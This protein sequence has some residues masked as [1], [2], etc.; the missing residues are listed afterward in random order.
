M[1]LASLC[2]A[3]IALLGAVVC[4]ERLVDQIEHV[5]IFMQENRPMDHYFGTLQGVRGFN[6]RTSVPLRS[7]FNAFHQPI[8]QNNLDEYMLPF[9]AESNKTNAMCMPA[10]EMYYPT[11][12]LMWNSGRMDSWNT[13]RD[14]GMGM[15]YYTRADLPYYY[16]LYDN[17]VCGDQ[18]FQSTF[19]STTP[20]RLVFFSG[21]N[22]LSV[23]EEAI[24]QN[25]E[26]RPGYNWTTMGEILEENNVS[27]RVYQ[28]ADNFDDNGFAWF[29]NYQ[30]SRPGDV[31]FEK[32]MRRQRNAI[33]AFHDD[34]ANNTLPQV[35]WII[36]PTRKSEHATNHPCDGED[37]TARV[38]AT[39]SSFPDIYAKSLFILNYD[40]GKLCDP[41]LYL[42][43]LGACALLRYFRWPL[44]VCFVF[45]LLLFCDITSLRS[46]AAP[47]PANCDY[48]ILNCTVLNYSIPVL[49]HTMLCC[50]CDLPAAGGY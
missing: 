31:L 7:G 32:G 12:I 44:F 17:F 20:N 34:L 22:G 33:E 49:Y 29:Y 15:S 41:C 23:G 8:D 37:F 25:D 45:V 6:D 11:D 16:T 14:P 27:W 42:C 24:L 40:E 36:A 2:L 39:L 13:A 30:K 43:C 35:S 19:T 26:P 1:T 46:T 3:T 18:Y 38:L 21:S 47:V 10:P 5:I 9:R 50:L 28:Q 4:S 48:T